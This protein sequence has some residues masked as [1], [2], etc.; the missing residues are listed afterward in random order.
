MLT[1]VLKSSFLRSVSSLSY[2]L[3]KWQTNL[4]TRQQQIRFRDKAGQIKIQRCLD[5]E[6]DKQPAR[7]A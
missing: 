2:V 4:Q 5:S 3:T 1:W 7:Q 6:I